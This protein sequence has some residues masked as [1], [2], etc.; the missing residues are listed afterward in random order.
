MWNKYVTL[1]F[2]WNLHH[3]IIY[4][5]KEWL[6]LIITNDNLVI[7][8]ANNNNERSKVC[9]NQYA[10]M[11]LNISESIIHD[12][13][14]WL[15]AN[16]CHF[17]ETVIFLKSNHSSERYS[18]AD[19]RIQSS[20]CRDVHATQKNKPRWRYPGWISLKIRT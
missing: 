15:F 1:C 18:R 14:S 2:R 3:L 6:R 10:D 9:M 11:I 19:Y 5:K 17:R 12:V 13:S 4:S 8:E 16:V 20:F 7:K